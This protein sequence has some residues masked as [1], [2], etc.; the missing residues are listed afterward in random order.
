MGSPP[1]LVVENDADHRR[2]LA[3][4]LRLG[5]YQPMECGSGE[6]ALDAIAGNRAPT[7][8]LGAVVLDVGLPGIDG[9]TV[10]AKLRHEMPTRCLPVVLISAH[11]TLPN[12]VQSDEYARFVAKP[13]HPDQLL[14][15]LADLL[16]GTS[17]ERR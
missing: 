7:P 8:E 17:E 9:L 16:A 3:L 2:A 14:G 4:T 15:R 13:F 11:A 10:L 6:E 1:I 5:G 12:S